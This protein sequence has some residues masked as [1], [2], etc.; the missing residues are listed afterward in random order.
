MRGRNDWEMKIT[1]CSQS[2]LVNVCVQSDSK[3]G[4]TWNDVKW[5]TKTRGMYVRL[6]RGFT[7]NVDFTEQDYRQLWGIYDYTRKVENSLLPGPDEQ[8]I[9]ETTLREFQYSET[10]NSKAFT[11]ERVKR[12]RV[13][14]FE[15][16][17]KLREGTGERKLHRGYRLL[18][19]TSPKHKSLSRVDHLIG[20]KRPVQFEFGSDP[21]A[22]GA[23]AMALRI[24]EDVRQCQLSLVFNSS[25]DRNR[26]YGAICGMNLAYEET[27]YAQ[28]RLNE[29]TV[30]QA[31][32]AEAL[33]HSA[34]TVCKRLQWRDLSVINSKTNSPG[35][36]HKNTVL[37]PNL[38]IVSRCT[39]GS[40]TDRLNCGPGELKLRLPVSGH[41]E[42]LV[43][44]GRQEDMT[45]SIDASRSEADIPNAMTDLLR[46]ITSAPTL[47]TYRFGSLKDLHTFQ[48]AIT[49]F[50]VK[51][52]GV[53]A[54]FAISRRRM[55]VPIYKQWTASPVRLQVVQQ[56]NNC[57]LVAFFEEFSHSDS[58]AFQMKSMD[59]FE[60]ADKG[61]KF[62]VK[63]VD[64]KFHL[65]RK[66]KR[67]KDGGKD[68]D[69]EGDD[70][71]EGSAGSAG[72]VD[73]MEKV[74]RRFVCLDMLEYPGEHDDITISFEDE[75]GKLWPGI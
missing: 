23:P 42:L 46:A 44:R 29:F 2:P 58:M 74:N 20:Q 15:R 12:C 4:S 17:K 72:K 65:P 39:S 67:R 24:V 10:P 68:S 59:V 69:D 18:V 45:V 60:K 48:S 73:G 35:G 34:R 62:G 56:E 43:L 47:R 54:A 1:I 14:V 33:L 57:V 70:G 38:R 41:P 5:K 21:K 8:L 51:Y 9:Q 61:G 64:A 55:V 52:D 28:L 31:D 37:S 11:N 71:G 13:R 27:S 3:L 26:F 63:L 36:E 50:S 25:E 7:L 49:G 32:Q 22:D 19:V 75:A 6:P 66:E 16:A 53:A 30:D 40:I